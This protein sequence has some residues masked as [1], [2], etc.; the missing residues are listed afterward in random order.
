MNK[1][2]SHKADIIIIAA[3]IVAG[4]IFGGILLL[5]GKTGKTVQVRVSG[6]VVKTFPLAN[7]TEYEITGK[8]GGRNLLVIKDGY[9]WIEEADCPDELCK[10]MGKINLDGQSVI[11]L[12]HEVVVEIAGQDGTGGE[13][14]DIIAE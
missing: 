5:T 14:V 1:R 12:P 11:C 9:A 13:D 6:D 10:N 3:L 8:N 2:R 7:D 4:L